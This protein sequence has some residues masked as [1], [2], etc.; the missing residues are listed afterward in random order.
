M[1]LRLFGLFTW[2]LLLNAIAGRQV[3]Q[4]SSLEE[5]SKLSND[6]DCYVIG[7]FENQDSVE[8]MAYR[9]A[10][11]NADDLPSGITSNKEI[12]KELGI[13]GDKG[14]FVE[15]EGL[16]SWYSGEYSVDE[17][18]MWFEVA[19][20]PLITHFSEIVLP[21]ILRGYTKEHV[22]LVGSKSSVDF[23][24]LEE[25]FTVAAK[26]FRGR[27]RYVIVD[28]DDEFNAKYS[29]DW[30]GHQKDQNPAVYAATLGDHGWEKFLSDFSD[31]T[32]HNII[33]Y[34]ERFLAGKLKQYLKSEEIPD[35]WDAKPVQVLVGK[36]FLEVINSSGKSA[37]VFFTS[38]WSPYCKKIEPVWN[39]LGERFIDSDK[40]LIAKIN[41]AHHTNQVEG[42]H[43]NGEPTLMF[44]PGGS[45][46]DGIEYNGE[47]T[48]DEFFKFVNDEIAKLEEKE[49]SEL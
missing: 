24:A 1:F 6:N 26:Q 49:R 21:N 13:I 18:E 34:N 29:R 37:F 12:K 32:T 4:I 10:A 22:V 43:I 47:R 7:Y 31:V 19:S 2:S 46:Q 17:I 30:F 3:L 39:E 16:R 5:L 9:R 42:I 14:I 33:S 36:N 15:C 38:P 48:V 20:I 8:A 41:T 11:F 40:V 28:T 23:P 25:H 27:T 45:I 44:F 35:D